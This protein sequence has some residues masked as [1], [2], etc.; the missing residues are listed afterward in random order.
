MLFVAHKELYLQMRKMN[1]KRWQISM[2][3][4]EVQTG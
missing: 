1:H 4:A 3:H 2:I